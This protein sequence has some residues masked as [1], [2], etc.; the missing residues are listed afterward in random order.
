MRRKAG[1]EP[2]SDMPPLTLPARPL[3]LRGGSRERVRERWELAE[4]ARLR[5]RCEALHQQR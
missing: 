3:L 1:K 5:P 4:R 2:Y